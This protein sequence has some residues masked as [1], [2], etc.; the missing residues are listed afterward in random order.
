MNSIK[1]AKEMIRVLP[2]HAA[3]MKELEQEMEAI[4]RLRQVRSWIC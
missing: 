4:F 3:R 2:A 1:K